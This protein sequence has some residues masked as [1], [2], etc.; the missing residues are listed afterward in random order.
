MLHKMS[1][2]EV[3]I[4]ICP[5]FYGWDRLGDLWNMLKVKKLGKKALND[6]SKLSSIGGLSQSQD[7]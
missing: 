6:I 7:S 4:S 5:Y 3:D 1:K 2:T